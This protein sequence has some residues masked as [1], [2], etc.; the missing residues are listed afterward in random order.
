MGTGRDLWNGLDLLCSPAGWPS[1]S[2]WCQSHDQPLPPPSVTCS[3]TDPCS[4]SCLWPEEKMRMRKTEDFH[5]R[6]DFLDQCDVCRT[7]Q[8]TDSW[9]HLMVCLSPHE[10]PVPHQ[11]IYSTA[12]WRWIPH[13]ACRE[14]AQKNDS[15]KQSRTFTHLLTNRNKPQRARHPEIFLEAQM[16]NT[17]PSGLACTAAKTKERGFEPP[18]I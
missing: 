1:A 12:A 9:L 6:R 4:T 3:G 5:L 17:R 15:E 14:P 10:Q 2:P 16:E 13:L 8:V 18:K 11:E 7:D